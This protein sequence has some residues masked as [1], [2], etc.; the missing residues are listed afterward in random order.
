MRISA[1]MCRVDARLWYAADV[2]LNADA[3]M[4]I[5]FYAKVLFKFSTMVKIKAELGADLAT[6][7]PHPR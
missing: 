6:V 4:P 2:L 3:D 1:V 5:R 7:M